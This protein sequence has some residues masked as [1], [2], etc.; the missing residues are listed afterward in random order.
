[1]ISD[2][3]SVVVVPFPFID[4]TVARRRPALVLSARAFNEVN[5]HTLLA[6]I[7]TASRSHW[8]SD[9]PIVD[10]AAAGLRV[11]C[12]VRLKL[13]TLENRLLDRLIGTLGPADREAVTKR[14]ERMLA[15]T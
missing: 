8:P 12:V 10:L 7:T 5:G 4:I 13:F 3:F 1:M 6:M 15:L 2:I 9:H 11:P 14:L